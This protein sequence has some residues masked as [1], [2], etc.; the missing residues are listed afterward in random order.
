MVV[1]KANPIRSR[2]DVLSAKGHLELRDFLAIRDRDG[3]EAH[4]S[5]LLA[6]AAGDC[7]H[8]PFVVMKN[9]A[10]FTNHP[11]VPVSGHES[12]QAKP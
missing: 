12:M 9:I 2:T 7:Q 3:L 10:S 1:L 6:T 11:T 4:T 5:R 8:S